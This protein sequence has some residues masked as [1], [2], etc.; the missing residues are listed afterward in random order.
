MTNKNDYLERIDLITKM[1]PF[2]PNWD[3]LVTYSIPTWYQDAK[4][5]IFIHWGIYAV[6]AFGDEWYPRYMYQPDR[7]EYAHHCATYGLQTEFGYKDFIPHFKAEH[8][9]PAQW[10]KLFKRAG[11][12]YVVPVAE[13]HDGFS[14]YDCSFS[15]WNAVRMGPKR[16]ILAALSKAIRDEGLV[17]GLSSH[18]AEHWFYFNTAMDIPSDAQDPAYY[19][20]Y[21]PAKPR[22][23]R[24]DNADRSLYPDDNFLDDWLVRTCELVDKYQPQLVYFDWWIDIPPFAPYLQKFAAYYYNR[25]S[26]WGRGVVLNFKNEA[27]PLGAAVLDIERGQ[28]RGIHPLLWQT[29]TSISKNS[30]GHVEKQHYKTAS[31]LIHDLV[32][33]VSKNG[34]LLLNIGPK[35]DG[36]IP[37]QEEQILLEIGRWLEVNGEAIY[38]TRPWKVYGEGPTEVFEGSITETKRQAFTAHD[39]RFTTRGDTLYAII[40]GWPDGGEAV[41]RSLNRNLTLQTHAIQRVSMLGSQNA[42]YWMLDAEGLKVKLPEQCHQAPAIVLKIEKV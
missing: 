38:S 18:R 37:E 23:N 6:P 28:M 1:G 22:Y 41:I 14:M 35:A 12:R 25:S 27:F 9:D 39:I 40:L 3:S 34:A 10:A 11:A 26:Q 21:G 4:F 42:L 7:P 13:H 29:C 31:L 32:D 24:A 20:F 33:I 17:F 30:W 36:T 16:D 5:G 19:D 2:Q 8:F 15:R